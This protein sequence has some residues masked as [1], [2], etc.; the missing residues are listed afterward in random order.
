M[1]PYGYSSRLYSLVK[2]GINF[3]QPLWLALK[4]SFLHQKRATTE[5]SIA[6]QT[7]LYQR[8]TRVSRAT[9]SM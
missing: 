7:L 4:L 8:S 2:T 3:L 5:L 1:I 9:H 6:A